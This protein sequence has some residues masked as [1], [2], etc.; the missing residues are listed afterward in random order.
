VI[1]VE[2]LR[3]SMPRRFV[4]AVVEGACH[5]LPDVVNAGRCAVVYLRRKN[6]TQ[7]LNVSIQTTVISTG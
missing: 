6:D 7:V 2:G 3:R 5:W 4:L 1:G